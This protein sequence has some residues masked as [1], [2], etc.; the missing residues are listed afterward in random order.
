[1][2]TSRRR[3]QDYEEVNNRGGRNEH[4]WENSSEE[5]EWYSCPRRNAGVVKIRP[6]IG[7][8]N[9]VRK[10]RYHGESRTERNKHSNDH[11]GRWRKN[12][13]RE[14]TVNPRFHRRRT[15]QSR[16]QAP[17]YEMVVSLILGGRPVKAVVNTRSHE[18]R[19]GREV[20][21]QY[22]AEFNPMLRKKV[23]RASCRLVLAEV[24]TLYMGVSENKQ[25]AIECMLDPNMH[26]FEINIGLRALDRIG[27]FIRVGNQE[28]N[29]RIQ[30]RHHR[31]GRRE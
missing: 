28:A 14:R 15:T 7:H 3:Y 30:K 17:R 22:N 1:M 29:M 27:L 6:R 24:I 2:S 20:Y 10:E 5:E 11:Q 9:T 12:E 23:I 16:T 8:G 4:E 26:P 25:H 31:R 13:T 18:T 19:V 21:F